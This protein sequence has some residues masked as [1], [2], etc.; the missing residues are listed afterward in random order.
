MFKSEVYIKRR[1]VLHRLMRSGVGIFIGHVHAPINYKSNAYHFRQDSDFLYFFGIDLPGFAGLMDFD[2][3]ED[4]MFGNDADMDDIIWTGP[5]PTVRELAVKTGISKT[6]TIADFE[7]GLKKCISEKRRIH[8]LPPYR[9][10]TKMYLG[11]SLNGNPCKVSDLASVELIKAVVS[12]RSVKDSFE[13]G[14][15]EKAHVIAGEM[16]VKAMKMCKPGIKEKDISGTIDGIAYR[17]GAGPAF[18]TI[19]SMDGQTLHNHSH[20]NILET[21]RMMI[22]D[23]GAES[24]LHYASDITRTTPVGGKFNTLQKEIYEIVLRANMETIN[25]VKPGI[26]NLDLHL[27]AAAI[28]AEGLKDIGIMKGDTGEAVAAG[29]HALFF[30]HGIGHMLGLDVHDME[31]LGEDYVGYSET[32]KRSAQFGLAFLRLALPLKPGNVITIEPGCY[33]IPELIAMWRAE[34]KF[35][36]FIDYEKIDRYKITGGVRIEDNVLVT[37]NG[38]R[39]LGQPIPKTVDEVESACS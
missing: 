5:Q 30:P 32:V 1:A 17:M 36:D 35:M 10:E 28:I 37:E 29:A 21:G 19:L 12:M 2:S 7:A 15:I 25:A 23:G 22:V 20:K 16:H 18:P 4:R 38:N 13:I 24:D 14:E 33:F 39:V 9:A 6:G 27:S 26:P 34:R 31:G 11:Q 8:F 3:G